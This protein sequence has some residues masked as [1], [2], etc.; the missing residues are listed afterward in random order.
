M[1]FQIL[2]FLTITMVALA[3]TFNTYSQTCKVKIG[4]QTNGL[5]LYE[6]VFEYDFV[7]EKPEFP[8]GRNKMINFINVTREYP[9]QAYDLGIEGRVTC[10][11]IVHEDGRISNIKVLK[12]VESSLNQEAV[13]IISL[14]P[15]WN[16]GKLNHQPV[17][18]RVITCIPFRK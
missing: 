15:E 7:D 10:A 17:P 3:N 6:E 16:P 2:A 14:M 8:G 9:Q 13:R 5:P 18:V 12:G 11:F 4:T 1:N